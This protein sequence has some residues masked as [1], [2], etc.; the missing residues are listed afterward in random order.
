M[1]RG[2]RNG[3]EYVYMEIKRTVKYNKGVEFIIS[4]Q[5]S[6]DSQNDSDTGENDYS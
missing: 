5:G 3:G 1:W 2:E 4:V 6:N